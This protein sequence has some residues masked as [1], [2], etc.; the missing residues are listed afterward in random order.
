MGEAQTSVC[1]NT[2]LADAKNRI[3]FL[4]SAVWRS[5]RRPASASISEAQTAAGARLPLTPPMPKTPSDP[6]IPRQLSARQ[7][8]R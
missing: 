7:D 6:A 1:E 8:T 2:Y 3:A 4:E 5:E